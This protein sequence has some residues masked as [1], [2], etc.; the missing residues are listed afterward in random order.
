MS[1]HKLLPRPDR[2]DIDHA[3]VGWDR[4]L[5]TFFAQVFTCASPDEDAI[6]W[7]GTDFREITRPET[8]IAAVA[9]CAIVPP[10]LRKRLMN[11]FADG[12]SR[13]PAPRPIFG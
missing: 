8:A 12:P 10:D 13:P 7:I 4:P 5:Q 2:P 11:D 3:I 9:S 1:R 6:V